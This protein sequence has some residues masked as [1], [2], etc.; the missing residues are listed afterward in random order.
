MADLGCW[1]LR[2]AGNEILPDEDG[3]TKVPLSAAGRDVSEGVG[4][5]PDA[6]ELADGV[7]FGVK[8][9]I[10]ADSEGEPLSRPSLADVVPNAVAREA[11]E[12]EARVPSIRPNLVVEA[13]DLVSPAGVVCDDAPD[14]V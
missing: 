1:D 3:V 4:R 12:C 5:S 7:E 8:G 11:V 14:V 10:G 13:E 6:S 9:S 2:D